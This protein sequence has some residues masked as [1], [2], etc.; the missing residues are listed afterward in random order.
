MVPVDFRRVFASPAVLWDPEREERLRTQPQSIGTLELPTGRLAIHDPGYEFAPEAL[1]GELDPGAYPVDVVLRSWRGE[2]GATTEAALI[3]AL[4]IAVTPAATARYVA[5]RTSVGDRDL[6]IGVDSG[7]VAVFDRS[8]LGRLGSSAIL[9]AIPGSAPD[10]L[11]E[12]PIAHIV[13]APGGGSILVSRAGMGDGA[14]RAWWGLDAQ[15]EITELIVDFSLLSYSTWQSRE[16][17]VDVLLGSAAGLRLALAR[18]DVELEQVPPSSI[19]VPLQW[20]SPD[21]V[22]AFRRPAGPHWEFRLVDTE[23]VVIGGP[24][25]TQLFPGP[26]FEIF[27]REQLERASTVRIRVHLGNE[28]DEVVEP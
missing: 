14:Y 10:H 12:E 18:L 6:D 19:G 3:A 15:R 22:V 11:V 20:A 21:D 28:P 26:W 2:D 9:D 24:G 27:P 23:G 4:R 1:N 25:L 17:P 8:L 16:I 7:L 5:V 13:A